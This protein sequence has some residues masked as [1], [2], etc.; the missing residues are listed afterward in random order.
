MWTSKTAT[1]PRPV[2]IAL[3]WGGFNATIWAI[4]FTMLAYPPRAALAVFAGAVT[5]FITYSKQP[6]PSQAS[7]RTAMFLTFAIGLVCIVGMLLA[8]VN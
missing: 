3:S 8:D 5:A 4:S 6:S 1:K 7:V 2:V